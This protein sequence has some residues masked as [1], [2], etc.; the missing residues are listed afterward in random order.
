[1]RTMRAPRLAL[2]AAL[3]AAGLALAQQPPAPEPMRELALQVRVG[4]R[5]SVCPCPVSGLICDDAS[6]VRI[7][8]TPEAVYL[9]G[10]KAGSTL[11][12]LLGPNRIRRTYRVTVVEPPRRKQ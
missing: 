3:G 5:V 2:A 11:C 7:V 9:E 6:L 4:E 1:M 8:E 12:G 10:V